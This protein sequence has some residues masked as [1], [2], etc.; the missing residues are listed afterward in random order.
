M[1]FVLCFGTNSY[2]TLLIQRMTRNIKTNIEQFMIEEQNQPHY[3]ANLS[4]TLTNDFQK[5]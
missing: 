4:V 3:Y 5:M 2:V 1:R